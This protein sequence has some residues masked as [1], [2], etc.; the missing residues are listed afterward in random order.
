MS[1]MKLALVAMSGVMVF[2]AS[3]TYADVLYANPNPIRVNVGTGQTGFSES[4]G[5]KLDGESIISAAEVLL[6]SS[7]TS[8][9][10]KSLTATLLYQT[11][12]GSWTSLWSDSASFTKAQKAG[13]WFAS[14]DSISGQAG[15]YKLSLSGNVFA[16]T[17]YNGNYQYQISV[18]PVPEPETYAL[19]GLGL[20]ALLLRRKKKKVA[21]SFSLSV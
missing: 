9:A 13:T 14:F 1:N 20:A 10:L 2:A 3:A 11:T 5:F 16:N 15:N 21:T 8:S 18:A 12:N 7:G 6:K 19:M 4:V 17:T